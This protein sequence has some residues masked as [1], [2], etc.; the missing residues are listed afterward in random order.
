MIVG[1]LLIM[2]GDVEESVGCCG[3]TTEMNSQGAVF[4]RRCLTA[5][6]VF[7]CD[8]LKRPPSLARSPKK[9]VLVHGPEQR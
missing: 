5:V 4:G 8:D 6:L 7:Q 9:R 3:S 1:R 2:G